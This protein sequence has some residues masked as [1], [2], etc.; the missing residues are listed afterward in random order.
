MPVTVSICKPTANAVCGA[1]GVATTQPLAKQP[2]VAASPSPSPGTITVPGSLS[3]TSVSAD[4]LA[5]PET[6]TL[7]RVAIAAS[8]TAAIGGSTAVEVAITSITD[9]AT[10]TVIYAG[11]GVAV[12][13]RRLL[14]AAGSHDIALALVATAVANDS[15]PGRFRR[16]QSGI[17][18][19]GVAVAYNVL[20]P[21]SVS[22][23][24]VSKIVQSTGASSVTFITS[25]IDNIQKAA[26]ASSD[27]TISTG[28]D[29][30]KV[31]V[32]ALPSAPPPPGPPPPIGAIVGGVVGALVAVVMLFGAY[33]IFGKR[34]VDE[35][36]ALK[37]KP[38]EDEAIKLTVRTPTT[39]TGKASAK[40]KP[41]E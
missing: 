21:S 27:P 2:F 17:S 40:V 31:E 36:A 29:T 33:R 5:K 25:V 11:A 32:I 4:A 10:G 39:P 14:A 6:L 37:T 38:N 20:V 3:F 18:A 22:A 28:F 26:A 9:V 15:G 41:E 35:S 34:P 13:S 24:T 12:T 7:L 19:Q 16:L 23:T 8:V 1:I 30:L